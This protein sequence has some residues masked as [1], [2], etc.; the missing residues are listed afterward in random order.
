MQQSVPW[1]RRAA[2]LVAVIGLLSAG[3][4]MAHADGPTSWQQAGD[5]LTS[6]YAHTA[7]VLDDGTVLVAGGIH[8]TADVFE[9][10]NTAE[11][12]DPVTGQAH[13][14]GPMSV[15]RVDPS[16]VKLTDGRVFVAGGSGVEG[17]ADTAEI[18]DPA[19][20]SWT[21]VADVPFDFVERVT[22]SGNG[23]VLVAGEVLHPYE[24][25]EY[26]NLEAALFDPASA[27]W[28]EAPMPI[29]IQYATSIDG[30]TTLADGT[31][32]VRTWEGRTALFDPA[33]AAW[34]SSGSTDLRRTDF[35]LALPD[36][37]VL[38]AGGYGDGAP[39]VSTSLYDPSTRQ[40]AP[41]PDLTDPHGGGVAAVTP[42]GRVL[43]AG[44]GTS[45]GDVA[46]AE[47]IDPVLMAVAP[48]TPMAVARS[49]AA[50]A[51]LPGGTVLAIGGES[52]GSYGLTSIEALD[53]VEPLPT[54]TYALDR[55]PA[56][57]GW[58]R[59]PVTATFSCFDRY[60][61][62]ISCSA[63]T[64]L[65]EGQ[66][67][68]ATG[69]AMNGNGGENTVTVGPLDIDTS[70]PSTVL[71]T[72]VV[73]LATRPVTAAAVSGS[74]SDTLSGVATVAVTFSS[75]TSPG[76][77]RSVTVTP[78]DCT[79]DRLGCRWSAAFPAGLPPG[80]YEVTAN[81]AD[82]VGWTDTA[83]ATARVVFAG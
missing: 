19:T 48:V 44:G 25:G 80:V 37:R 60:A 9:Y 30:L 77:H 20:G 58:Y 29:E 45:T 14:V 41:G 23:Q 34:T 81:A 5:L 43:L 10:T 55:T 8:Y 79:A 33:T 3:G 74:A 38:V 59:G 66:G 70:A 57:G 82:R 17:A 28:T 46:G 50:S 68:T 27:T 22:V 15:G 61:E 67:V 69:T 63:P 7:T 65:A 1:F 73:G 4:T 24:G 6:R 49:A 64:V 31:V 12:F 42:E 18:F 2:V 13:A 51:V 16:A 26:V 35:S 52:P 11:V 62:I 53:K 75:V 76:T 72:P 56:A 36:G 47:L 83:G 78:T 21:S 32:L 54:I 40:W 39:L 71:D